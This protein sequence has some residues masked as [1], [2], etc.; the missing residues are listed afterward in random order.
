MSRK[1]AAFEKTASNSLFVRMN[2][3]RSV[4]SHEPVQCMHRTGGAFKYFFLS[5]YMKNVNTFFFL[6]H[7]VFHAKP[8]ETSVI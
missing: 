1:T 2:S 4:G 8:G 7:V 3:P 5:V 6:R